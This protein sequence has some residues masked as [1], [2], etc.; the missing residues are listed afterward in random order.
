MSTTRKDL[1]LAQYQSLLTGV[2]VHC[3]TSTFTVNGTSYTAPQTVALVQSV[4]S[5]ILAVP[6]ARM[7]WSTAHQAAVHSLATDG[8]TV[9]ELRDCMMLSFGNQPAVLHDL[10]FSL[11]KSPKPLTAEARTAANAKRKATRAARGTT[12]KKQ[13]AAIS[14]NVTGVTITPITSSAVTPPVTTASSAV[15]PATG[16]TPAPATSAGNGATHG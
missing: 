1:T 10:G 14:G 13:K 12:S 5:A 8:Q 11:R 15:L 3:A 6:A 2:P 16:P 4:L 7:A 9:K